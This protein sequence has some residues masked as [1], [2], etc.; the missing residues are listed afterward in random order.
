M[1]TTPVLAYDDAQRPAFAQ[2]STD[3]RL[4]ELWLHGRNGLTIGVYSVDI[5]SFLG[6]VQK[7]IRAI[8]LGDLQT[9]ADT[10]TGAPA[11][12]ARRIAVVRSLLSF[13]VRMGYIPLNVGAALRSP[14]ITRV[15]AERI[16]SEE[17]V[18]RMLAL[19]RGPR[20]HALIRLLYLAALRVSEVCGLRWKDCV[21]RRSGGQ[22]SVIG[23]RSKVRAILLPASMW[24]ELLKLKGG[25]G[26]DDFVFR[27]RGSDRMDP[28]TV[29]RT[30]KTAAMRAGL[31][32]AVS[33][34]WLRHSHVSHALERGANP[35]LVRD[36]AGHADLR[37]TSVYAHAR[38]NDSSAR[39][40]IA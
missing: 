10:L 1:T 28:V 35:A 24:A 19:E 5:G 4:I 17:A 32:R 21:T 15:L 29:Q 30:V 25:A 8:T 37:I 3:A 34:H 12:R 13:A 36:T 20:S 2:A 31:S 16:L 6:I 14:A 11:T 18:V 39:Y 22:V 38:P 40:L 27:S 23:K 9:W 33:P 26:P 7:P